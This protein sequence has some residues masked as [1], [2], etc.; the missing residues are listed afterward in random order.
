MASKAKQ[1]SATRRPVIH[2]QSPGVWQ[3]GRWWFIGAAIA[4]AIAVTIVL[5]YAFSGPEATGGETIARS[6]SGSSAY[7]FPVDHYQGDD[8]I[9]S[10]KVQ[11]ASL[12]GGRPIVLNYLGV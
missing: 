11:F 1:G 5:T 3:R 8:V 2:R 10:E 7:D 9:G 12:L 4:G 6:D